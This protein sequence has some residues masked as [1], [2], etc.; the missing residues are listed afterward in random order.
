GYNGTPSSP[1]SFTP[2]HGCS[3]ITEKFSVRYKM[4]LDVSPGDYTF[5]VKGDDGF[6]LSLDGGDTWVINMWSDGAKN[7]QSHTLSITDTGE[8]DIVLEYYENRLDN[9][10]SFD[11]AFKSLILPL[12]WGEV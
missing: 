11:F 9:F 4:K 8:V 1:N 6:R 7:N 10:I 5:V 3:F 2:D 12:E